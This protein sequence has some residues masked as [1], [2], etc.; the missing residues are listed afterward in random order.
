MIAG[1]ASRDLTCACVAAS[2]GSGMACKCLA[3]LAGRAA[4][5]IVILAEIFLV[6]TGRLL[7]D[8]AVALFGDTRADGTDLLDGAG[9]AGIAIYAAC[10]A[11]L[12][13][14]TLALKR[15]QAELVLTR[16]GDT[17]PVFT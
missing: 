15:I 9:L 17:F 3:V 11:A 2:S 4:M 6:G 14:G 7:A 16:C 12:C 13:L 5:G 8:I 1:F 10:R